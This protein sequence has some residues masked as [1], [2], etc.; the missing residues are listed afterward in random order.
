MRCSSSM[1]AIVIAAFLN[2]LK[3][4]ITA[5]RCFTLR[6]S[7]SIRLFRYFDER[8]VASALEQLLDSLQLGH[9]RPRL[10][11]PARVTDRTVPFAPEPPEGTV[12]TGRFG[13]SRPS[14][15]CDLESGACGLK[16]ARRVL[17]LFGY[18]H[19][20]HCAISLAAEAILIINVLTMRG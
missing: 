1:P 20:S 17:T 5:M 9:C 18:L 2:R 8:S 3:P 13:C 12:Q 11:Q 19:Q 14:C 10:V 16:S 6:W 7:C 4:S 15:T